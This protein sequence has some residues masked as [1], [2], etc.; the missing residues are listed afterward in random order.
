MQGD[1]VQQPVGV[2]GAV[3]RGQ[4]FAVVVTAQQ[5]VALAA[6]LAQ[7]RQHLAEGRVEHHQGVGHQHQRRFQ[8]LRN[9]LGGAGL[10]Q[11]VQ[12]GV[13]AGAHQH[14][15]V[16]AQLVDGVQD[17]LRLAGVVEGDHQQAGAVDAGPLQDFLAGG[18]AEDNPL[19][20]LA[21][22][23]DAH[24]IGVDGH[25]LVVEA[26][27]VAHQVLPHAAVT[28]QQHM[29]GGGLVHR[30]GVRLLFPLAQ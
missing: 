14:A 6:A 23:L 3:G 26:G 13:V 25:R 15:Q 22:F 9:H 1:R 30:R 7:H 19:T 16:R 21:G 10:D 5:L 17:A 4:R 8:H 28:A 18:V 29:A 11:L 27:Q 2:A 12:M 24:Q 20:G